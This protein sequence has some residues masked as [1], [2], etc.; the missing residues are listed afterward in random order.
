M[1]IVYLYKN[2]QKILETRSKPSQNAHRESFGTSSN[3]RIPRIR[4][5]RD[6]ISRGMTVIIRINQIS[7]IST[8]SFLFEKIILFLNIDTKLRQQS[9]NN[10]TKLTEDVTK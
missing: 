5:I 10:Q 2:A 1:Y 3:D 9:D 7:K 4:T 6:R 8:F